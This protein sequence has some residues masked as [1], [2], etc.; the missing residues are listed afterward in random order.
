ML[1]RLEDWL[2][3][4]DLGKY[5]LSSEA[6]SREEIHRVDTMHACIACGTTVAA[7]ATAVSIV[8]YDALQKM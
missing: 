3:M 5:E 6:R 1:K 7:I 2:M 8:I 4:R